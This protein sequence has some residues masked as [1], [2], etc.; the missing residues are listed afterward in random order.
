M[1]IPILRKQ[2][3][4]RALNTIAL[5]ME[6]YKPDGAYPE[7]FSYWGYGNILQLLCSSVP[8]K[9]AIRQLTSDYQLFLDV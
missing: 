7:G 4:D 1:I 9:N 2:I 3:I 6:D 8:W 5:P